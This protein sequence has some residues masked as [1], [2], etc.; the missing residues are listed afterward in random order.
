VVGVETLRREEITAASWKT[1]CCDCRDCFLSR[2]PSGNRQAI[3]EKGDPTCVLKVGSE[4]QRLSSLAAV[5]PGSPWKKAFKFMR[6]RPQGERLEAL[7]YHDDPDDPVGDCIPIPVRLRDSL[8][9]SVCAWVR[10]LAP[11]PAVD[12]PPVLSPCRWDA[13][14]VEVKIDDVIA[15]GSIARMFP[16]TNS[17]GHGGGNGGGEELDAMP[18]HCV[19]DLTLEF[20]WVD[21]RR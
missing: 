20:E 5:D 12:Y 14:S 2:V 13:G 7:V 15:A 9:C 16:V 1:H 18:V 19:L 21:M 17:M 10:G 3:R 4:V 11:A 6:M 8:A